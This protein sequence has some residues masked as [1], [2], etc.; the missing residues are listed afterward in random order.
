MRKV[1]E[2]VGLCCAA[3]ITT[4]GSCLAQGWPPWAD[5]GFGQRTW[6]YQRRPAWEQPW[7]GSAEQQPGARNTGDVKNGGAQPD[8][9]P[10]APPIVAFPHEFP[11]N[12]IVIDSGGRQLYYVLEGG[13]AYAYA[14]S[15]G[16]E[17]FNW[18]GTETI[19]RKQPW[20]DWYPPAEMRERDSSLPEKMTGGLKNPLGAMALYLGDTLYRIH[21]TNDVKSIGQA[22]SSGCFRMLNSAVLHL[23]SIADIGTTVTV[24]SSLP[25]RQ[26]VSRA[27]AP[28]P[29]EP[30]GDAS[31][32]RAVRSAEPNPRPD[33]APN[34]QALR[35]STLGR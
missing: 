31:M 2:F 18:T 35:D 30:Q 32:Q 4:C 21:G 25:V 24:V 13:R 22:Q 8:I 16:R 27:E 23:A 29:A 17:G 20:P 33:R 6:D 14:T 10:V 26:E 7:W 11:L 3:L 15:V 28:A 34:Y 9:A 19:S 12:S 1:T 5:K